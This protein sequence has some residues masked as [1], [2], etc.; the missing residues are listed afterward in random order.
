MKE[1]NK[2]L[3]KSILCIVGINV[4]IN[5]LPQPFG[6]LVFVGIAGYSLYNIYRST[7]F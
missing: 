7:R 4:L 6:L 2:I 3:V 5:V 1:G